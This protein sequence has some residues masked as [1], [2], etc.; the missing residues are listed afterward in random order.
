[1]R[2]VHLSDLHIGKRV[3]DFSMIED[4][5]YIL[6]KIT[7]I[8]KEEKADAVIIAGDI[9]DKSVPPAEAVQVFDDFLNGLTESVKSVYIINGNHDSAE[10]VSFGSRQ[11]EKG[12]VFIAPVFNGEI[13]RYTED[14]EYGKINLYLLPYVKPV[15]VRPFFEE[16][17]I[18]DTYSAVKAV[19]DKTGIDKDERNII[20]S[21]Q[22]ITGAERSES[23]EIYVG[24]SDN[25]EAEVFADF[26]YAALGHLHRPQHIGRETVR[27]CGT[28]LK[29]SFSEADH[30]KSVTVVDM[31]EKGNVEIRTIPLVPLRD[32]RHIKGTY[33][34]LTEK[35]NYEGTGVE[36]Y[37]HI[38]LLDEEE[39]YDAIGRLRSI[40]PNIM[41][42]DY[43][44][45][46]TS[47]DNEI[48]TV[49]VGSSKS[50]IELFEELFRLQNNK[51][52]TESQR[53]LCAEIIGEIWEVA[54]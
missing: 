17:T 31:K 12:G 22:F 35:K 52:F 2:F 24:G 6:D 19:I 44:N 10:R 36:D 27:Y 37:L 21:H 46:R 49:D 16:G 9:Y 1:M 47:A 32:M 13:K 48:G 29:Y 25:V 20:V 38:T 53:E 42:I 50:A 28:P 18:T 34:Y 23:E 54:K 30:K 41:R 51:D 3:N 39:V 15:S 5:K 14:D 43:E 45:R 40:Y 8:V 4:Q 26:D 7:D 33:E 11:M